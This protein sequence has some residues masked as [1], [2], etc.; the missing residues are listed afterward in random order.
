MAERS[1]LSIGEVLSLL[2][3]EFPDVTISKIRFLESQGLVDPERTPSGYRKFYEHDVDRLRWILQQ[4]R[5]KFLPLKVIR[6]K[7]N[8]RDDAAGVESPTGA[9]AANSNEARATEPNQASEANSHDAA[10]NSHGGSGVDAEAH[11]AVNAG[12][13]RSEQ[14]RRPDQGQ[15]GGALQSASASSGAARPALAQPAQPAGPLTSSSRVTSPQ[16]LGRVAGAAADEASSRDL[17]AG[18]AGAAAGIGSSSEPRAA[19]ELTRRSPASSGTPR[20]ERNAEPSPRVSEGERAGVG[21]PG[22]AEETLTVDELARASGLEPEAVRELEQYGLVHGQTVGRTSYYDREALAVTRVA[23]AFARHGIGARHLRAYRNSAERE[24]GLFE[25]VV[26]PLVRQRN[27]ASRQAAAQTIEELCSL[28]A[29][30][31]A[32]LIRQALGELR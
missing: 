28:G 13:D 32:L 24:A 20:V 11:A 16:T 15:P 31:R 4:Q 5:E 27:P 22:G 26:L 12:Q 18:S 8:E 2:R 23:A 21:Q 7:L 6:G 29:D 30:L 25:A 1:H 3:D 19:D 14:S 17:A 10:A 9:T